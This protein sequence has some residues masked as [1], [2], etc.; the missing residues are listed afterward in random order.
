MRLLASK[1]N[2]NSFHLWNIYSV[3]GPDGVPWQGRTHAYYMVQPS[4]TVSSA[5]ICPMALLALSI[6]RLKNQILKLYLVMKMT[7]ILPRKWP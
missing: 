3:P 2:D 7:L 6:Q 5:G 1:N 4:E